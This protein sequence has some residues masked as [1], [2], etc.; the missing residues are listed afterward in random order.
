M[1]V[2][3]TSNKTDD[4]GTK[5]VEDKKHENRGYSTNAEKNSGNEHYS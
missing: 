4:K 3:N 2:C 1:Y 5:A